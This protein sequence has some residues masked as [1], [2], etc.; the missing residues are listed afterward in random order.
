[1]YSWSFML[2]GISLQRDRVNEQLLAL[3]AS[4]HWP[5][6][7]K[8]NSSLLKGIDFEVDVSYTASNMKCTGKNRIVED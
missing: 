3:S 6:R 1:M 5:C 4:F 8:L 7:Q 2:M